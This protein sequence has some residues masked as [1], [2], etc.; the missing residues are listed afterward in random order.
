MPSKKHWKLLE[1]LN[2]TTQY[3]IDKNIENPRLNAEELLGKVLG[4]DRVQLYV[5]YEQPLSDKEIY[6]FRSLVKRRI[7]HEPLQHI[8]GMTEFMGY[9]IKVNRDV[10]IP[11]PETEILVE[12]VLKLHC[13]GKLEKPSILDIGT[14]S[15]CIAVSLALT[16]P[17][18]ELLAIDI[19]ASALDVAKQNCELNK[20]PVQIKDSNHKQ[21]TN[22]YTPIIL[23]Q[24]DIMQSWPQSLNNHFDIIISNPP[25][26]TKNEINDLQVEVRDFEPH[27]ALTD[28]DDGL[29]F[30]KRI[31]DMVKSKGELDC[32]YLFLEMSGS[33]PDRIEDLAH[34]YI[35]KKINI[36]PDLNKIDRV[37]KIE[38]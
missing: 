30:Y 6:D 22:F 28:H 14:G 2:T 32:R 16:W 18:S 17:N 25:Y 35:F 13:E 37:L 34:K 11:R 23:A 31:F 9:P 3:F 20:I 38:V 7:H 24:L 19:S 29:K 8:I 15:G 26:V 12:G 5:S 27:I 36:I 10:L 4:I 1:I 21:K 33:H